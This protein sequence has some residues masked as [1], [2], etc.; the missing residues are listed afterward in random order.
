MDTFE[1]LGKKLDKLAG[2]F[3][4][5]AQMGAEKTAA[6]T[7]EWGKYLDELV[8]KVKKT[9]QDGFEKVAAE[10]KEFGQL[11]K[12][13]AQI[14]SIKGEL[15][16]KYANMGELAF[17]SKIYHKVP[18]DA[19]CQAEAFERLEVEISELEQKLQEKESEIHNLK[20]R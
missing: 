2:Q 18:V 17:Q 5:V 12:L 13:R 6:E 3:K 10:T 4:T 8:D 9:T 7:K 16:E 11:T 15:A 1:D 20:N 19:E 14:R